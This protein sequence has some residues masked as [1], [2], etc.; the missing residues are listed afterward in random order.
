MKSF[1][2]LTSPPNIKN[3]N[4]YP[5]YDFSC[6]EI[7]YE[8]SERQ[9]DDQKNVNL[10]HIYSG[11]FCTNINSLDIF[12]ND[13]GKYAELLKEFEEFD[14][15]FH[16]P[17]YPQSEELAMI[18]KSLESANEQEIVSKADSNRK[19]TFSKRVNVLLED[20]V[21]NKGG[22]FVMNPHKNNSFPN[23]S[24]GKETLK[25]EISRESKELN[26]ETET[27]V[28]DALKTTSSNSQVSD[29][30]KK[31]KVGRKPLNEG[32]VQRKDVVFKTLLR[33]FRHFIK[34][35]FKRNFQDYKSNEL[36][37]LKTYTEKFLNQKASNSFIKKLA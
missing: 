14:Q 4:K 37:A 15:Y 22:N 7:E 11:D 27:I 13:S 8:D 36:E 24:I 32:F 23:S 5:A 33:K 31:K 26:N 9:A 34:S 25:S 30:Q 2:Q 1:N 17:S 18:E 21:R 28:D 19:L 16:Y 20:T 12:L 6:E 29:L 35:D 10:N 3:S